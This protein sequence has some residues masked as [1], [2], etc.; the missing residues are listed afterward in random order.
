[1][2]I[3]NTFSSS[4][5][6]GPWL[7]SQGNTCEHSE[8]PY[9]DD[10]RMRTNFSS[11]FNIT[12]SIW[13]EML[14]WWWARIT[15]CHEPQLLWGWD[16]QLRRRVRFSASTCESL[17]KLR[18]KPT[19]HR[20]DSMR[21][22]S[23]PLKAKRNC[24]KSHVNERSSWRFRT[25]HSTLP[26]PPPRQ[27]TWRNLKA[28]LPFH[29][30]RLLAANL[31]WS[32]EISTSIKLDDK[33]SNTHEVWACNPMDCSSEG[34]ERGGRKKRWKFLSSFLFSASSLDFPHLCLS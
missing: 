3:K 31:E 14:T 19:S 10:T 17:T 11:N 26:P 29:P 23:S 6:S 15:G 18:H 2:I 34:Y 13:W 33:K 1:M 32:G 7:N 16:W 9:D 12:E 25:T 27:N 24:Y 20:G 5:L 28:L 21:H 4:T 8:S 22:R 30:L